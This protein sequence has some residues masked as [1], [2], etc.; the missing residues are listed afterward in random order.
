VFGLEVNAQKTKYMVMSRDQHAGKNHNIKM[1]DKFFETVE[2]FRYLGTT[3]TNKYSIYEEIRSILKSGN[4]LSHSVQDLLSSSLLSKNTKIKTYRTIILPA[5]LY[6]CEAWSLTFRE[7]HSRLGV[8]ENRM[9]RKMFGPK[10]EEVTG[11]WKIPHNEKLYDLHSS[12][13]IIR[14]II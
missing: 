1:G 4:V 12:Q 10:R 11:E 9:L 14:V 3:L 7:E 5:V 8:F 6:G 13:N 2:H